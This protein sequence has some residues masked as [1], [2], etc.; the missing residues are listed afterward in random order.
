[1]LSIALIVKTKI[2]PQKSHEYAK[3]NLKEKKIKLYINISDQG[4]KGAI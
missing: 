4:K 1:M 3:R 2:I